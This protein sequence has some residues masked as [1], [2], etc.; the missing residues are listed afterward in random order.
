MVIDTHTHAYFDELAAKESEVLSNMEKNGVSFA[1]QIGCDAESSLKAVEL[2]KRHPNAYRATV[3]LHPGEAQ[4]MSG[5]KV[6]KELAEIRRILTE[7]REWV[8]AIGETGWDFYRLSDDPATRE[9]EIKNQRT[10][11][12]TQAALA[13][14]FDLPLVIHTRNSG[15]ALLESLEEFS[16]SRAVVHC[17][18][19]DL[20]FAREAMSISDGIMF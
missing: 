19:E 3:G 13:K 9:A 8:V 15:K 7:N 6:L 16:I 12:E 11:F 14:E 10:A 4:N 1:V 17:F 18:S 5:E 2:A 20:A